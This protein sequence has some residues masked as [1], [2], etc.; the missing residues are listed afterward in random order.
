MSALSTAPDLARLWT[1]LRA[2]AEAR[3]T[4]EPAHDFLHVLRVTASARRL[5]DEEGARLDV[6]IPAALLHELFNY[7]KGHPDSPRSGEV[8]AEHARAVLEEEGEACPREVVEAVVMCIREHPFSRGIVPATI[9]GKVLLDAD[10]LDAIGAIGIA[11]CFHVG[12]RIGGALYHP[13]DPGA[14]ARALND[15]AYALDHF[16]AKL[17]TLTDGFLTAE[18]Q[19][20]AAAR[21][22]LMRDFVAAFI[23]ELDGV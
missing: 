14:A 11:R 20:L 16:A 3:A 6:V 13:D 10:R 23:H 5:A 12:G 22:A 18:G 4:S 17:F 1:R 15:Q 2:V 8:C 7:P 21:A 9:E 19:R